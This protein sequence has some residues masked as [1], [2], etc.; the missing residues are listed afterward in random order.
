M[1]YNQ[2]GKWEEAIFTT[3]NSANDVYWYARFLARSAKTLWLPERGE[4]KKERGGLIRR[5]IRSRRRHPLT[6]C[7][8]DHEWARRVPQ[9]ALIVV[10]VKDVTVDRTYGRRIAGREVQMKMSGV[11]VSV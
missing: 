5:L 2:N 3:A 10:C 4:G 7:G 11:R 1:F 9:T 6:T 8:A